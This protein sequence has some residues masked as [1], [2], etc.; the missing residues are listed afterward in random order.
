MFNFNP[1]VVKIFL[2][3]LF[4]STIFVLQSTF[5]YNFLLFGVKI[6]ILATICISIAIL[7]D[8]WISIAFGAFTGYLYELNYFKIEGLYLLFFILACIVIYYLSE[9]YFNKSFLTN[10]FFVFVTVTLSKCVS[11]FMYYLMVPENDYITFFL[12]SGKELL[13]SLIF[14]PITYFITKKIY[15]KFSK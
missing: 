2:Y 3:I 8:I 12:I 10:Y 14:C 5:S 13:T 15:Y 7:D 6:D 9:S 1:R 4:I 11:Y